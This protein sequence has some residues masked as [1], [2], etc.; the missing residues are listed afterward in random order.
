M[1]SRKAESA[2]PTRT[3][4]ELGP[5]CPP[6]RRIS[7]V[8]KAESVCQDIAGPWEVDEFD[9]LLTSCQGGEEAW[10]GDDKDRYKRSLLFGADE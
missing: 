9:E 4:G 10:K 3:V 7:E 6:N 8:L 2:S 5:G 1:L